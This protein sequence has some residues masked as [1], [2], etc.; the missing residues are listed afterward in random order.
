MSRVLVTN[1]SSKLNL[2]FGEVAMAQLSK[3]AE[4]L[5]NPHDRELSTS[6]LTRQAS[7]CEAIVAYRGTAATADLFAELPQLKAFMRCATDIRTID[8]DAASAR[9]ILVT[10]T[11]PGFAVAVAEWVIGCCIALS[12]NLVGYAAAYQ[13][14]G[15]PA[16]SMGRELRGS[17]LGVI[18]HGLIG[19][20]VC[21]L[22]A[23][24]GMRILVTDPYRQVQREGVT[25][26]EFLA[27]LSQSDVVVCLAQA[28]AETENLMDAQA[29]AMMKPG[30]FF[31]NAARGNLVNEHALHEALER[32]QLGGC[33][34]DV[35]RAADQMPSPLLA[36]HPRVIA[37][38]HIG[39]LTW[40]AVDYQAL[41]TVRQVEDILAGRLPQGAVNAAF[42]SRCSFL[43]LMK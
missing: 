9:G 21:R 29:F 20:E 32:G 25:Q 12:R 27:L 3:V 1:P 42:A 30:A 41:E 15:E 39:G 38:P 26:V 40:P 31:I 8:V 43:E 13:A 6:E 37:T 2:Y 14:Q 22:A 36:R 5:L 24:F 10:R 17:V 19:A 35:G 23:A 7:D 11:G 28:S 33:A 16:V 18:G 34:I 4:V